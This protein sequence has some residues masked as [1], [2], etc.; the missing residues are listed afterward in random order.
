ML[1]YNDTYLIYDDVDPSSVGKNTISYVATEWMSR[2]ECGS[3]E[4]CT[5]NVIERL[6]LTTGE[7]ERI[8]SRVTAVSQNHW[9]DADRLGENRW[10]V[11]DMAH[12]RVFVVNTTTKIEQWSWNAQANYSTKSGGLYPGDLTHLNDVEHLPDGRIMVSLR[13]Q[14]EVAFI[15]PKRGFQANWTIGEDE[16]HSIL[17]EQHNPDYIPKS[18][19]GP[20]VLI[21]DSENNRIVEY[22]RTTNESW[23]RTW[24]WSDP[25][26][27]WPRDADR[28][29]NKHTLITDTNG[30]RVVKVNERGEVVW[31]V[32]LEGPYE[33]ERIDTADESA[34]GPSATRADL[35]SRNERTTAAAREY[36]WWERI[37]DDV[38]DMW[39]GI[40]P[41]V[42]LNPLLYVLPPWI[43]VVELGGVTLFVMTLT[44][45]SGAELYWS[46]Y[47]PRVVLAKNEES[48]N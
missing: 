8:Y 41:S 19:G 23:N 12:D 20:A 44:G 16:N 27:K 24:Q 29:P 48:E 4:T 38:V 26:L 47:Q 14:D 35:Q 34:G 40:I 33:G 36:P 22:Q 37:V 30:G 21:A 18:Q 45:W 25:G 3:T 13:N 9:H 32:T 42:I 28:L 46:S 10:F 2:S 7:T 1:Y 5:R 11:A 39:S 17:Y 43:G 15:S 31:E 6:N